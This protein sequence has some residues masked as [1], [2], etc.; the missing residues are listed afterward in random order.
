MEDAGALPQLGRLVP[1][2]EDGVG[3]RV[4]GGLGE[5]DEE[6]DGDD[7]VGGLGGGEAE[8]Q[9]GPDELAGRDPD[10]GPDFS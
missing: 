7:V 5:A 4:E 9:D 1:G 8:G 3:G 10:G 2:A 6:A